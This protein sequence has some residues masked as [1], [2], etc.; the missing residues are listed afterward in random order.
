TP[1]ANKFDVR[2]LWLKNI[3]NQFHFFGKTFIWNLEG[4]SSTERI[5]TIRY[6]AESGATR[7]LSLLHFLLR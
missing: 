7:T 3:G 2:G 5:Q 4:M 6:F 1:Q